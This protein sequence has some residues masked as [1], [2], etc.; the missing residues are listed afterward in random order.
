M[1]LEQALYY[2]RRMLESHDY[3]EKYHP[4]QVGPDSDLVDCLRCLSAHAQIHSG[5]IKK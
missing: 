1:E 3:L 4:E 5:K 2:A